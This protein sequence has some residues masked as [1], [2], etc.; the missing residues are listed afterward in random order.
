MAYILLLS[1]DVSVR[2]QGSIAAS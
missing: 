2:P 1:I